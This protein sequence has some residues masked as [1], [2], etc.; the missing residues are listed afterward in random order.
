M[1]AVANATHSVD[2]FLR[3]NGAEALPKEV[4]DRYKGHDF[5]AGW[6]V[7]IAGKDAPPLEVHVLLGPGFP[8]EAPRIALADPPPRLTWPHVERDGLLCIRSHEQPVPRENP[9]GVVEWFLGQAVT[10]VQENREG[11]DTAFQDEFLS[12]WRIAVSESGGTVGFVSL[13]E[14]KGP[15]RQ[16][17]VWTSGRDGVVAEDKQTLERW[18]GRTR[19][20]DRD[21]RREKFLD[22]ALLWLPGPLVPME[23]PALAGELRPLID[24][25]APEARPVL[26]ALLPRLPS[27]LW[28][29]LGMPSENG[30]C[31]GMVEVPDPRTARRAKGKRNPV[32]SGFRPGK[33]P[34]HV[35]YDRYLSRGSSVAKCFV[36]R[37]DHSW[38]HGR[39]RDLNQERLRSARVAIVGCGSLGGPVARLLAQAGIGKLTLVDHDALAWANLSRHVLGAWAVGKKKAAALSV[40][41]EAA[42]PHLE[43][44]SVHFAKLNARA[45]D[46]IAELGRC[47]LIVDATGSWAASNL[48][49]DLQRTTPG[50]PPVVYT[51][52]EERAAA[53][54]AVVLRRDGPC[55]R[56]GFSASGKSAMPVT[57]W[58]GAPPNG[59]TPQCGGAF[60]PYGACELAWAHALVLDTVVAALL[61][62]IDSKNH[63]VWIGP[64]PRLEAAGAKWSA[65]WVA[66]EGDPGRGEL[67]VSREWCRVT[68]C[69]VCA[70]PESS[71]PR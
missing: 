36:Q 14:P 42:Y 61:G 65:A 32:S 9:E 31:F 52:M 43:D 71:S 37:A 12:Y 22:G 3:R 49:N 30:V 59:Q 68:D 41:L 26:E 5:Q 7:S 70:P 67:C 6:L 60:T 23:Y 34:G 51:W 39:G 20:A 40:E 54:H 13:V 56:C 24:Q 66:R 17:C 53:A 4:I 25:A 28:I 45:E 62:E 2:T 57:D 1:D 58:D 35:L 19:K 15:S 46:L 11:G 21:K 10:L 55:L 38:V 48:L 50:F 69:D 8:Y 64:G 63:R 33:I 18:L 44:V 29:L 47:E 16:V 27:S